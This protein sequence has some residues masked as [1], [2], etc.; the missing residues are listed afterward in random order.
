LLYF[1]LIVLVATAEGIIACAISKVGPV[2]IAEIRAS[3]RKVIILPKLFQS[4]AL[5]ANGSILISPHHTVIITVKNNKVL[6]H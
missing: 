6:P 3:H 4:L 2:I 5:G 1:S